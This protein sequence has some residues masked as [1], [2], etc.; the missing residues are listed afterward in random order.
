LVTFEGEW[1]EKSYRQWQWHLG[2]HVERD[3]GWRY[4]SMEC[5]DSTCLN[6]G[7]GIKNKDVSD[8]T[9]LTGWPG[10]CISFFLYS[11]WFSTL[12]LLDY[13]GS[14]KVCLQSL[15][16]RW[17]DIAQYNHR[18]EWCYPAGICSYPW[19]GKQQVVSDD[20]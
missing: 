7:I 6:S 11:P 3:M 1:M 12:L 8:L 10:P 19:H 15:E 16:I 18:A 17:M 20:W 2:V 13:M 4:F 9:R 5:G 14:H